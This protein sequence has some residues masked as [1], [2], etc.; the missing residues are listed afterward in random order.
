MPTLVIR[1]VYSIFVFPPLATTEHKE[2][3]SSA[4]PRNRKWQKSAGR[5]WRDE[6]AP[7]VRC[8]GANATGRLAAMHASGPGAGIHGGIHAGLDI[9]IDRVCNLCGLRDYRRAT[10]HHRP[11]RD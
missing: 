6:T 5:F 8:V 3:V 11:A 2:V 1:D 7:L 9:R 4:T 10:H